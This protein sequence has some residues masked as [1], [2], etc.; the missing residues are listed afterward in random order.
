M[1]LYFQIMAEQKDD[2]S[3]YI[4]IRSFLE[5]WGEILNT[6][7]INKT[8]END[9]PKVLAEELDTTKDVIAELE[10]ICR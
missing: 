4:N 8:P 10:E 6:D 7:D 2:I 9:I 5:S 3:D 1:T